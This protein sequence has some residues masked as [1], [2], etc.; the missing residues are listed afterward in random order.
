MTWDLEKAVQHLQLNA[1]SKSSG[2]C[3]RY[4]R[5]AIEAGG[6]KL[7]RH[8]S[9]KNYGSSLLSV[10]FVELNF[11][12]AHGYSKGD[13]AVIQGF[14]GA[15]HGHMQMYDGLQWISDFKQRDF[16]PGSSYRKQQ[17]QYA[18]YRYRALMPG[19]PKQSSAFGWLS[20]PKKNTP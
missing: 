4:V 17:P 13:V 19:E 18:V 11:C 10:E 1:L 14:T 12:P 7:T 5:Q 16:W 8:I 2:K 6:V 9:A 15:T 20:V 3:A